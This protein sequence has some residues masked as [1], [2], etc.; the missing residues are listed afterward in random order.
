MRRSSTGRRFVPVLGAALA[1]ACASPPTV[2]PPF[3]FFS[4]ARPDD[5]PWYGK[6][7]E[8][9]ARAR[10]ETAAT[11]AAVRDTGIRRSALLGNKMGA[12]EAEQ[13]RKLAR[14]INAWAQV[15]ARQHYRAERDADFDADHWPTFGEL[16]ER[17]GDD[18]DGLDLITYQLLR[19]FG[20]P[21][22]EVYRA[23]VRRDR[24]RANHMV[25]LWFEDGDDPWVLDAT[26]AMT[27][28]MRRFSELVGWTPTKMFNEVEQYRVIRSE[29]D[30]VRIARDPGGAPVPSP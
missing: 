6:V 1:L 22:D 12:F 9:Q 16:I 28:K 21:R 17:N 4:A 14:R 29:P 8:W 7:A 25:T 15:Q 3:D 24:D 20:Y 23:V 13:K 11:P 19:E 5:D 10:A 27:L 18:C 2:D 30:S 26:G